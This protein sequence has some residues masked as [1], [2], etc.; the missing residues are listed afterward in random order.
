MSL[1]RPHLLAGYPHHRSG[2]NTDAEKAAWI[3]A[4]W[5]ILS[6]ALP[7]TTEWASCVCVIEPPATDWGYGGRT[8]ADR[9][10]TRLRPLAP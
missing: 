2:T 4:A 6:R 3:A 10:A 1:T 8:Q 9:K 7:G 5:E